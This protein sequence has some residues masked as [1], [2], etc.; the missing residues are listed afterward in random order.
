MRSI[1]IGVDISK[2]HVMQDE[3]HLQSPAVKLVTPM[4]SGLAMDNI[5]D[6]SKWGLMKEDSLGMAG[7]HGIKQKR[8]TN[9]MCVQAEIGVHGL[10]GMFSIK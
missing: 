10:A 9:I 1:F 3:R 7:T 4:I 2:N 8:P 6:C 5:K